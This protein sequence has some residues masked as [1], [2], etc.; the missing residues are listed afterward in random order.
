MS[1]LIPSAPGAVPPLGNG[2]PRTALSD[3]SAAM[4]KTAMVSDPWLTANSSVFAAFVITCWSAS[5]TPWSARSCD[6]IPPV[7]Y[8]A[9]RSGENEPLAVV[10][11]QERVRARFGDVR[12]DVG[13]PVERLARGRGRWRWRGRGRGRGR[14]VATTGRDKD[15]RSGDHRHADHGQDCDRLPPAPAGGALVGYPH[16]ERRDCSGGRHH[17]SHLDRR[18]PEL[19]PIAGPQ[20]G[21]PVD[22]PPVD[23]RPVRRA[24]VRDREPGS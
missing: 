9:I 2:E 14:P 22:H 3:P 19:D 11:R 4:W 16:R 21:R 24:E 20:G 8:S 5:S 10:Q 13:R 18:A 1:P 6:P 15:D 12:L 7:G 23:A 17:P